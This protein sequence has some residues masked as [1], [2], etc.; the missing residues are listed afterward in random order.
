[1][2]IYFAGEDAFFTTVI[3]AVCL[4][5][6]SLD[7]MN[8]TV[9]PTMPTYIYIYLI[10]I[11]CLCL[12]VCVC[13]FMLCHVMLCSVLSDVYI[14]FVARGNVEVCAVLC[15]GILYVIADTH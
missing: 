12:C 2:P 10:V 3:Q 8:S 7:I 6:S 4:S 15:P 1:M 11:S 9:A 5:I 14:R 13:M